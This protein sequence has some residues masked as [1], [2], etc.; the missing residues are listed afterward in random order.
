MLRPLPPPPGGLTHLLVTSGPPRSAVVRHGLQVCINHNPEERPEARQLLKSHFFESIRSGRLNCPGVDR[1]VVERYQDEEGGRTSPLATSVSE[2]NSAAHSEDEA[3]V[4]AAAAVATLG[5]GGV[6]ANGGGA[7]AGAGANGSSAGIP[8]GVHGGSR[9]AT[10]PREVG[11]GGAVAEAAQQSS[12]ERQHQAQHLPPPGAPPTARAPSPSPPAAASGAAASLGLSNGHVHC[13]AHSYGQ[14]HSAVGTPPSASTPQPGG[15][16][17]LSA[18]S[19]DHMN[20]AAANAAVMAHAA[21]TAAVASAGRGLE[22]LGSDASAASGAHWGEPLPPL[23]QAHPHHYTPQHHLQQHGGGA[24][25]GM[26]VSPVQEEVASE[27]GFGDD[28]DAGMSLRAAGGGQEPGRGSGSGDEHNGSGYHHQQH[29]HFHYSVSHEGVA[30]D[31]KGH[32]HTD[33]AGQHAEREFGVSC[34]QVDDCKFS[35]QLRFVEPEGEKLCFGVFRGGLGRVV[36]EDTAVVDLHRHLPAPT[37]P[38]S[39]PSCL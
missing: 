24:G 3:A 23:S 30:D 25:S 11:G 34:Q 26:G 17:A 13:G 36:R 7:G 10:P 38:T 9:A 35:F 15:S 14:H 37:T 29:H 28:S 31:E 22:R 20:E 39:T 8:A 27:A 5:G 33:S 6:G 18:C 2:A 21:A 16:R 19:S 1:S 12:A 4:V 32:H